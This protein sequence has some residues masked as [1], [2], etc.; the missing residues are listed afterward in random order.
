MNEYVLICLATLLFSSQFL[1]TKK[2]QTV[3]G[4]QVEASFFQRISSPIAFIV[5]MLFYNRF[6]L[7]FTPFSFV[8]ALLTAL[9]SN[10]MM[11]FSIKALSLGSVANY[12]LYLLCGGMVIPVLYGALV[13]DSF[14]VWKIASIALLLTAILVK[15]DKKEKAG[16]TALIAFLMLF[17][18]NGLVGVVSSLHQGDLLS[19]EK[20]S[21]VEF[22]I[23]NSLLS[24]AIGGV[25]FGVC[26]L[27]ARGKM[28]M[29]AFAKAMP[30]AMCDGLLNG[31]A[32]LFLLI[33]LQKLAPSLQYPMV[34][35]GTIFLSAVFGW[36]IY[37]EKTN[38]KVWLSVLL[39]VVGTVL[40]A[41]GELCF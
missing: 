18:L 11:L 32:N 17:L 35:G 37:K 30:W 39:A 33:S 34:T 7:S 19:L 2:Y 9:L 10:A 26:A 1:F 25:G 21:S 5:I 31:V 29:K 3:A 24:M 8:L 14:N 12:S 16:T 20:V 4:T 22:M 23:W 6:Q 27:R 28:P 36:L 15:F 40:M 38:K 41:V 13:G